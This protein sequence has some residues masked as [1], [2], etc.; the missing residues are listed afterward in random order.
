MVWVC[1]FYFGDIRLTTQKTIEENAVMQTQAFWIQKKPKT[2]LQTC[3]WS[4]PFGSWGC[5]FKTWAIVVHPSGSDHYRK[6]F[7]GLLSSNVKWTMQKPQWRMSWR[8]ETKVKGLVTLCVGVLPVCYGS[9]RK[10]KNSCA[11]ICVFVCLF[12][13]KIHLLPELWRPLSSL[14]NFKRLPV[15]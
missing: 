9:Q 14:H 6:T 7:F 11:I 10:I 15:V 3:W 8:F 2:F 13:T 4:D 12:L 1:C 5:H